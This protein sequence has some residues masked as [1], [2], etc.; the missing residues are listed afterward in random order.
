MKPAFNTFKRDIEVKPYLYKHVAT[1]HKSNSLSLLQNKIS[2]A[3]YFNAYNDLKTKE[4]HVITIKELCD[5]LNYKGHNYEEIKQALRGLIS[6]VIEWNM[7]QD[8]KIVDENWTASTALASASLKRGGICEYSYSYH[9]RQ[10]LSDPVMYATINMS[11]QANFRSKYGLA[12]YENCTRFVNV[13]QTPWFD[14][15]FFRQLMGLEENK[16]SEF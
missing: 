14:L 10:L 15:H 2:N 16:Y 6:T 11:Y 4:F 12:L 1:I 7:L 8:E 13:K 5:F 3:L 9:M